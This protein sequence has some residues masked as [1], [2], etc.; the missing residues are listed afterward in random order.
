MQRRGGCCGRRATNCGFAAALALGRNR[1]FNIPVFSIA[2]LTS[3]RL[4]TVRAVPL[5]QPLSQR[6]FLTGR[7]FLFVGGGGC[8]R[9]SGDVCRW[10][11]PAHTHCPWRVYHMP[12]TPRVLHAENIVDVGGHCRTAATCLRR[13]LVC[14]CCRGHCGLFLVGCADSSA[15]WDW[16]YSRTS[17]GRNLVSACGVPSALPGVAASL[18]SS[19][20]P[21]VRSSGS[22]TTEDDAGL[23]LLA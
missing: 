12:F 3:L 13:S 15:A 2:A 21:G 23:R 11:P 14:R 17:A 6:G 1:R 19:P 7:A 9:S 4:S 18:L 5:A 10:H 20:L 22:R 8:F 16:L